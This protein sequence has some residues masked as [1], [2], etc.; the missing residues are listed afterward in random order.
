MPFIG[1]VLRVLSSLSSDYSTLRTAFLYI[2]STASPS[3]TFAD[4]NYFVCVRNMFDEERVGS[5][6]TVDLALGGR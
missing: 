4:R 3:R 2:I 6:G 5:Q 1:V